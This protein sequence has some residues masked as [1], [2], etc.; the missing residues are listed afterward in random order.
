M[1]KKILMCALTLSLLLC[2]CTQSSSGESS[3]PTSSEADVSESQAQENVRIPYTY[4]NSTWGP[5]NPIVPTPVP[6][7][8]TMGPATNVPCS[9][10]FEHILPVEE[11]PVGDPN[12]TYVVGLSLPYSTNIWYMGT[13]DA[14]MIEAAKHPNI[15]VR[16]LNA[17]GDPMQQ[18]NDIET[19]MLQEVDAI[20][21][22]PIQEEALVPAATAA[23]EAGF[24][25]IGLDRQFS[26]ADCL[27]SQVTG[28]WN[29][30]PEDLANWTV[31]YLT[32]K[33]GDPRGVVAEIQT[34]MGGIAQIVRHNVWHE[35]IDQYPD[36]EV[37]GQ[38]SADGDEA[39]AFTVMQDIL[40]SH[41]GTIDIIYSHSEAQLFGAYRAL[42]AAGRENEGI[43]LTGID[44]SK[45]GAAWLKEGRIQA[46]SPWTPYVGDIG[47][48]LAIYA[49]EGKP[50]P[51]MVWLPDQPLATPENI[52][53]ECAAA[54]GPVPEGY[55]AMWTLGEVPGK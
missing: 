6:T 38:Q 25:V 3:A 1:L 51:K 30:G 48:R 31:E 52:D 12:R 17:D 55:E 5:G 13:T 42:E 54:Y 2:A 36:I 7:A 24:L 22:N 26:N 10:I 39:K 23:K 28:N 14:M 49:F 35:I 34:N 29:Q 40:A 47:L 33:Y 44:V 20:F 18:A 21:I 50:I 9:L 11:G 32:E 37:I 45:E 8:V 43:A 27:V 41:P 4:D 53:S 15:E 19:L 16:V 46:L